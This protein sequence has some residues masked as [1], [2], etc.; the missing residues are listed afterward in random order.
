M[1]SLHAYWDCQ[2]R[3]DTE[4]TLTLGTAQIIKTGN[5]YT[6]KYINIGSFLQ[7]EWHALDEKEAH[8]FCRQRRLRIQTQHRLTPARAHTA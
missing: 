5:F 6:I 8:E 7:N 3:G 4:M 1:Q 2:Q